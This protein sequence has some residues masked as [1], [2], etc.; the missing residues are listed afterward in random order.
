[1]SEKTKEFRGIENLVYAEVTADTADSFTCGTVKPLAP[2]AELTRETENNSES[3]YYDNKPLIVINAVGVDTVTI[4]TAVLPLEV[5]ADITGRTYDDTKGML[6]EGKRTE[7]YFA[8]GYKT[9]ATDGSY[10]YVWRLKGS[11]AIPSSEHSTEN[12]DTDANGQELVFTGMQTAHKFANADNDG[13]F[14]IVVNGEKTN[15]TS[16]FA[17]VQDPDTFTPVT[18]SGS[19]STT[20]NG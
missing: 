13:A 8:I 15:D 14:A 6:V 12:A 19:G 4:Q 5:L 16:F 10:R 3:H 17:T 18:N 2:V 1:M 9:K 20:G 11:F 7:K